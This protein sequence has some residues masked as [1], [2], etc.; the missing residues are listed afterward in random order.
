MVTLVFSFLLIGCKGGR[1]DPGIMVQWE[2]GKPVSMIVPVDLFGNTV[3]DSIEQFLHIRLAEIE[4]APAILGKYNTSEDKVAFRPLIPFTRG[5]KYNVAFKDRIIGVVNIPPADTMD[6]T[7][8][9]FIYPSGDT[10]PENLLKVYIFFSGPVQQGQSLDHIVLVRDE[11]DTLSSVFLDLQPELWNK[12]GMVLTLWLDPGR[13][14]RDLQPNQEL[15]TPLHAGSRYK[16]II[17]PGWQNAEGI[18]LSSLY[19]KTFIAGLRDSLS[20]VPEDWMIHAPVAGTTGSLEVEFHEPLDYVLL[21]NSIRVTDNKAVAIPGNLS[22]NADGTGLSFAPGE[23]WAAG[24]YI[25]EIESRLEDLA[26]NNLNRLFDT[27]LSKA[28]Q[29]DAKEIYK[30]YFRIAPPK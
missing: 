21:G 5:F 14:K 2:N 25:L 8:V 10:L 6:K 7:V 3:E 30:R 17:S 9:R 12:E 29:Q 16:L 23:A 24:G 11:H 18:P 19:E 4:N 26:G 20:P 15:G 1:N 27:D 28:T 13:V 22:V